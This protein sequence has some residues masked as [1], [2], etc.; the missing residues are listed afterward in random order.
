MN[1]LE[2]YEEALRTFDRMVHQVREDQWDG[3]TPC[4]EW[5]VRNLVNHL[6]REH[7]WVPRLLAGQALDE[8][9]DR[10]DGDVLG[11]DPVNAWKRSSAAAHAA[12]TEPGATNRTVHLS[13]GDT[14]STD[15]CWQMTCDLVVHAWDLASGIGS[16]QPIRED[17]A[18]TLLN[19]LGPRLRSKQGT[20]ILGI[21][22]PVPNDAPAVDR[23]L[24]ITGR[25]PRS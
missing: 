5:S 16:A 15:Y 6:V 21:G 14:P 7:L 17:I 18:H 10:Y 2:V 22:V 13:F 1:L 24:G 3:P 12:W 23:L 20:E 19:I 9:G 25:D 11:D 4:T 8:V